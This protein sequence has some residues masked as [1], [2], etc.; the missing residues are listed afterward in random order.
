MD[1]SFAITLARPGASWSL[2][3]NLLENLIWKD[4]TPPPSLDELEAALNTFFSRKIWATKSLFWSEFSELEK[5]SILTS[6]HAEVKVLYSELTMW[7]GEVWSDDPRITTGL[8]AL[9]NL[10]ILTESRKKQILTK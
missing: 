1:I 3:G 9:V 10:N 4:S 8:S 2:N 7:T 5:V 6:E